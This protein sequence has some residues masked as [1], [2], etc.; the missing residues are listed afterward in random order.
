MLEIEKLKKLFAE[1][2]ET[3]FH[4]FFTFLRFKSISTDSSYL[5]ESKKCA[6]WLAQYLEQ[7]GLNVEQWETCKVPVLF[8]TDPFASQEKKT[9]LIYCHYD[10]QPIDP[11]E[12]WLS[13]PFEPTLRDGEIYARG[14][15]DNKGQCFYTIWALRILIKELGQL[16]VNIKF[17]IEGEEESGSTGLSR[18]LNEKK[19]ALKADYLLIVDCGLEK[20]DTPAITLGAR[21]LVLL[22][23]SVQEAPFDLHS[24][25]MGGVAYNPNRALVEMLAKLHTET[26]RV[27]VEGFYDD[28]IEIS[29]EERKHLSFNPKDQQ[30][31]GFE[32]TGMEKGFSP[33]EA[34]WLRPTLEI[35]GMS[36][37]YAGPGFKTVIPAKAKA[38]ISCRLVPN[39]D[40]YHVASLVRDFLIARTPK[41]LKTEIEIPASS[42]KGFRSSPNCY[43][44][45]IM[46]K[47]Y[48]DVFQKP[49]QKTLT[50]GTIPIAVELGHIIEAEPILVGVA[51]PGDRVHSP[52]EHFGIDRFEKGFLTICHA[53]E[54]FC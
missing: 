32:P 38:K 11:I 18:I 52:N 26:G 33:Q 25:M 43:L 42:G 6:D 37:G 17:I 10:V 27:A 53:L 51:L 8:A 12:E 34:C 23:L 19:E 46:A 50:G 41:G 9:L 47:S 39:Q 1:K 28:V 49:C 22:E 5:E 36:G 54:L 16:P 29:E 3:I 20:A 40:P 24:G 4:D 45:E 44:A 7:S 2:K 31:F 35:N 30:D 13:D 14:A 15:S 21:G 48:S